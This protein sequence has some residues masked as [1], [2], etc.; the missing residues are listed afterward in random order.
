MPGQYTH[1]RQQWAVHHIFREAADERQQS[2]W[3]TVWKL[4]LF[5]KPLLLLL[6]L[7]PVLSAACSSYVS[8]PSLV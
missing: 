8:S 4:P 2:L 6:L 3:W 5:C 7:L 1:S